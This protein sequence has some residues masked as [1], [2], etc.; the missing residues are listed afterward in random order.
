MR[1]RF[2]AYAL[3]SIEYL[4]KTSGKRIRKQFDAESTEQ[5]AAGATWHE[6][7]FIST[8]GG[9]ETDTTA[10]LEFIARYSVKD[11]PCEHHEVAEFAKVDGEWLFIDGEMAGGVTYRREEPKVGRNDPCPCGSGK[12]FK[13]CCE[14]QSVE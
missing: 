1:S 14:G 10:K 13:K 5:W 3:S 12:K 2:T 4:Y 6:I 11:Q 7:E 9:S 8:E